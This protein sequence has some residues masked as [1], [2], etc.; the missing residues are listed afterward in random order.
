MT[1]SEADLHLSRI[2]TR[3]DLLFQAHQ[4]SGSTVADQMFTP[5]FHRLARHSG[6]ERP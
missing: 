2:S 5:Q 4:G 3:W 1:E 6:S